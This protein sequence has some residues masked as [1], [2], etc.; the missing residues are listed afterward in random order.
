MTNKNDSNMFNKIIK[1]IAVMGMIVVLVFVLFILSGTYNRYT[2][3][4]AK[5]HSGKVSIENFTNV[6][7]KPLM[8]N[9]DWDTYEGLYIGTEDE[10]SNID[11]N[12]LKKDVRS[13]PEVNLSEI[14]KDRTYR[15]RITGE[16]TRDKLNFLAIGIPFVNEDVSVFFNG[17]KVEQY[18]PIKSW[19]DGDIKMQMYLIEEV[20][21]E[22][23]LYQELIISVPNT[24]VG[25]YR[26]EVSIS[27]VNTYLEQT[28]IMD[29]IQNILIGFMILSII[30]G[31]IYIAMHPSYS[32]LTFMNLFDICK[33]LYILFLISDIPKLIFNT[34][35][36]GN[37]GDTYIRG[38]GYFFYFLAGF[39]VNML[40]QVSFD[41]DKKGPML[42]FRLVNALWICGA[43]LYG[44]FPKLLTER[45]ILAS[46]VIFVATILG[47]QKR[48]HI[49][50]LDGK[51]GKYQKFLFVKTS[52]L[53][54]VVFLDLVTM[55]DYPRNNALLIS[56]YSIFFLI[57]FF[58]RGYVYRKPF[59]KLARYNEELELAVANRTLALEEANRELKDLSIKDA[60]TG[61]Y[62]R[63]YFEEKLQA[64]VNG[65]NEN[66]HLCVFDLD[67][68]KSINDNFGHHE[69][70]EQLKELVQIVNNCIEDDV[71]FSRI[72]GEEFTL[73]YSE[74]DDQD[75]LVNIESIRRELEKASKN[76]GR[77]TGSFGLT[78]AKKDDNKKSLFIRADECL[79]QAKENGKN[80]IEY[81]F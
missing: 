32:V 56:L 59:D 71:I 39:F 29:A 74:M 81:E 30:M 47:I 76:E 7:S 79:Y 36:P 67:N 12:E 21:D 3:E 13:L 16:L 68:F 18:H 34:F 6:D 33:M 54:M 2:T 31:F 48:V 38:L 15:L 62:N 43:V 58:V 45:A 66:I 63:L 40:V 8:L 57:H 75:V 64:V 80:R 72:G 46:M 35:S 14:N 52:L 60:L 20:Y 78:K 42:F 27:R 19:L 77:T 28:N 9:G 11:F 41:P 44:M 1:Y 53:G 65:K 69:G 26:R 37:F 55:N 70:D 24:T 49:C 23:S 73:L 51:L 22:N 61:A 50:Y 5:I 10:F 4:Y 25:L 17:T